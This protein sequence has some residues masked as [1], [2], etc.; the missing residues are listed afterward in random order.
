MIPGMPRSINRLSV[1]ALIRIPYLLIAISFAGPSPAIRINCEKAAPT[2]L[3]VLRCVRPI[4]PI[5]NKYVPMH[6]YPRLA[7]VDRFDSVRH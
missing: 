4:T 2:L 7:Y 5:I 6:H 1:H 3:N